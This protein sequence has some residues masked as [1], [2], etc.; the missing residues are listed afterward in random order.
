[1]TKLTR[2]L[3]VSIMT[4]VLTVMALG[5]STFAWFSMN[6]QANATDMVVTAKSNATYLFIGSATATDGASA[7]T[8]Q[9][10]TLASVQSGALVTTTLAKTDLT[11]AANNDRYPAFF[12]E[13][14]NAIHIQDANGT[15]TSNGTDPEGSDTLANGDKYTE[16]GSEKWYTASNKLSSAAI[17]QTVNV[18]EITD[19]ELNK[20]TVKYTAYL[21]LSPDSENYAAGNYVKLT[22]SIANNGDTAYDASVQAVVEIE[23]TY[24][25]LDS[26]NTTAYHPLTAAITNAAL[27]EVNIYV[28]VN[29]RSTNVNSDYVNEIANNPAHTLTGKV[30]IQFDLTF[31]DDGTGN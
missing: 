15:G 31:E 16:I 21:T 24:Y 29:G 27:T 26:T 2:K 1:M 30:G 19:A 18:K 17:G 23:D 11:L 13:K 10:P 28:Y 7:S 9:V 5:T 6:T 14:A 22:F 3:F 12:N 20:Y 8:F 25:K 4:L